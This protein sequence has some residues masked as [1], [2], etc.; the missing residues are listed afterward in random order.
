MTNLNID[1]KHIL[2]LLLT[3]FINHA[4]AQNNDAHIAN[5]IATEKSV[6]Q[7]VV[8]QCSKHNNCPSYFKA[9]SKNRFEIVSPLNINSNKAQK[10][11]TII[12]L[13]SQLTNA[14]PLRNPIKNSFSTKNLL[15][16]FNIKESAGVG[17]HNYPLSMVI[18]L[19]YGK[20]SGTDSFY[21]LNEQ[22]HIIPAQFEVLNRWWGKDN[23]IRH[24]LVH[25]NATTK[26]FVKT[27]PKSGISEYALYSTEAVVDKANIS[28]KN[29]LPKNPTTINSD[30]K[31][32]TLS[33][34]IIT[35]KINKHPFEIITPA[36]QLTSIFQRENNTID[37]SFNHENITFEVE[38]HGPMRSIVKVSSLTKYHT[39][40]NIKHGW[41]LRIYTY[42]DSSLVKI[43]FQL[44]NS[45]LNTAISAPLYFKSHTL[46]L[47]NFRSKKTQQVRADIIP[48]E[49]IEQLPLGVIQGDNATVILRN[50]WQTFPN[51]IS[52]NSNG[53]LK[54]E[55]WPSWSKQFFDDHF[56]KPNIY[57][58]DDMKQVYKEMLFDFASPA[59]KKDSLHLA[60]TFQYPPVAVI[61]QQY[62]AKTKVTLAFNGVFPLSP[63][64]VITNRIPTYSSKSY[65]PKS[66]NGYKFGMDNYGLDL[67]RKHK[68]N[69]TGGWAYSKQ[70]FFVSGNPVDYY[71]AQN[72]ALAELNI[73][74]QWLAGYKD[75]QHFNS[76][77]P[78][79]N[80]YGGKTWRQFKGHKASTTTRK[81]I[82]GTRQTALPR[83]DQHAWFYHIEHAYLM[84]GNKWIKDWYQFMSEF[85]KI[86]LSER[87]PYPDRS[88]R[89]EG[90]ALSVAVAAYKYTGNASLRPYLEHYITDVHSK[91][92]SAPHNIKGVKVRGVKNKIAGFQ[93][94]FLLRAFIDLY[95]EFPKS[96]HTLATIE[97]YVAWN[98]QYGQFSYYKS[99]V[100][101][102]VSTKASSTA[103]T[104]VDPV[105]W[106]GLQTNKLKYAEHAKNF[107]E[108]GI[109]G[110]KPYGNW[111]SWAGQF[112]GVMY[113]FYRQNDP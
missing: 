24:I 46:S 99:I 87:D 109:G 50:F 42:A 34:N 16:Q 98:Y 110:V 102:K 93:L 33:N 32:I 89:A 11:Q 100:D 61:P 71:N 81:H 54:V 15:T 30:T 69:G 12:P 18:P 86:Y 5:E 94:G 9:S 70:Q 43:D 48:K 88:H 67:S 39:P 56:V 47:D 85:K 51:G 2:L 113:Q 57:W 95:T 26:T 79:T 101:N 37:Y 22:G 78:S 25:F 6:L 74:P 20:Y 68:T 3:I 112:E 59:N 107:V 65:D 4:S 53:Q 28:L 83:D 38:E 106:F 40:T 96:N 23:S 84:S 31:T 14:I 36:G 55:L 104:L 13:K 7:R 76:L 21:I 17:H 80:P 45:A 64:K 97:D 60:K 19:E 66:Y 44:Q 103:L 73:R 82:E 77:T 72:F 52:T 49:N 108:S 90:Q 41:A 27:Q 75:E 8:E 105:I 62:Y 91:Y 1:K 58:L 35:I 10:A 63:P 92:L 29:L 111:K